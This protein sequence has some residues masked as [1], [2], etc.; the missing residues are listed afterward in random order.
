MA[1]PGPKPPQEGHT[2]LARLLLRNGHQVW[3]SMW[4]FVHIRRP[5]SGVRKPGLP[6]RPALCLTR[7]TPYFGG[8]LEVQSCL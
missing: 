4:N 7:G 2:S 3:G 8:V 1:P 6:A 5:E